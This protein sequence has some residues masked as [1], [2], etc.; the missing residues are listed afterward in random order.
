MESRSGNDERLSVAPSWCVWLGL[1]R[2]TKFDP[3]VVVYVAHFDL[4]KPNRKP[5][6]NEGEWSEK[7]ALTQLSQ[8]ILAHHVMIIG[9]VCVFGA[10][11]CVHENSA[12][13]QICHGLL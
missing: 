5:S 13:V 7:D 1:L 11:D 12:S 9:V 3:L 10:R 6:L 2:A 4:G 8:F